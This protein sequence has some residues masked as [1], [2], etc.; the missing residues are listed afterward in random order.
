MQ[1]KPRTP[2]VH[3]SDFQVD[4][5]SGELFKWGRKVRLQEKPFQILALLLEQPGELVTREELRRK[6][7]PADTFVDFDHSLGTAISKLRLALGDSP[8]NPRFIETV[9]RRGYR[10]IAPT[11][12]TNQDIG[13]ARVEIGEALASPEKGESNSPAKA[14]GGRGQRA[15]LLWGGALLLLV[16][17]A[18]IALRNS[19][20][21][22]PTHSGPVSRIAITLPPDQ[23]L[24]GLEIGSALALSPDGTQLVYAA[25]QG[26]AQQ[27][28]L[29][30]LAALEAKPVPGTEGAVQ[31]FFSPDGRWLGFFAEGK[32]KRV[33]VSGGE[34]SSLCD[35]GD[36]RGAIW[37]S[38]GTIVFAPTRS[39]VIQQL[40]NAGGAP[41]P[42]TRFEEPE[43]SHRWPEFLPDGDAVLFAAF[44]SGDNWNNALI[45]VQSLRTGERRTLL[46][47][48]TNPRYAPSGHLVYGRGGN[49]MA[50]PFDAQKLEVTGAAVPVVEGI[51]Q[52]T[53]SGAAQ[54]SFSQ[55]GSL[56]YV[57]ASVQA[58][59]RRLVWVSRTGAEEPVLAPVRAYRGPRISPDGRKVAVAIEGQETEVWLYDLARGALTRLTFQG[60]SNYDPVWARDGRR[61]VFHSSAGL[62]GLF[63]QL[64]DGSG[65]LERLTGPSGLPYSWSP[66]GQLLAF[67]DA[68][69]TPHISTLRL[70]DRKVV[71]F[72]TTTFKEGAAE[73]SPDGRWLA[74]VSNESGSY[75]VY[76]QPYP[77]PGGKW[78]ISTEGGT[79]PLWNP[80]G[81]E[82]FYRSGDK[83]MAADIITHP[84]FSAGKPRVLFTGQ[85]QRS[86][87]PV[88]TANYDVS[89]DG[90]R[91]LMLKP[92]GRD[93]APTQINVA[94][95]WFEELKEKVPTKK[96]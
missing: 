53:F 85:F 64:A 63:W 71:P 32:L 40:S 13:H 25:H 9:A 23:P 83:L 88:P 96:N 67:R 76:V 55:N 57:P 16:A 90:K 78:Q 7:W 69:D 44:R 37:G 21:D 27:L 79:E 22:S 8:Q 95:N 89:S 54:Y 87:S 74:Y 45:S 4:L 41:R 86:P 70:G 52:S 61:V 80:N 33:S 73:F 2:R 48:G 3:F 59:Q 12:G 56:A 46:K 30:P 34:A 81:R 18:S 93:Q 17:F 66:N 5:H 51:L 35:A 28:Y 36:P 75:E 65:G 39:S 84:R 68:G 43:N 62:E 58:E 94:L 6:L 92:G 72:P 91:F 15:L 26:G 77:G 24:A 50:A 31:P 42:L 38:Q 82:L 49:L 29:R 1:E 60:S 11:E 14:I 20:P 10:F 19:K 47:G